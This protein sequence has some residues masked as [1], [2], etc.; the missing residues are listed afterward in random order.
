MNDIIAVCGIGICTAFAGAII[1]ELKKDNTVFIIL[2][3]CV[4]FLAFVITKLENTFVF[5]GNISSY[6]NETYADSVIRALGIVY[7]TS[8]ASDICKASGEAAVSGYIELAGRVEIIILCIPLF[9]ELIEL[10]M[11]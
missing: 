5:I 10:S 11:L 9:K 1:K 2:S 4:V 7:L 6:L 3:A 8:A